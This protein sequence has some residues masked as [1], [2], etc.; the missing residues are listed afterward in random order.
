MSSEHKFKRKP[1]RPQSSLSFDENWNS[2][3]EIIKSAR[4]LF[5][6]DSYEN[7]SIRK[8]AE[9]SSVNPALIR[10]YFLN[11]EG[12]YCQVLSDIAED[13]QN[14][15]LNKECNKGE[16][17]PIELIIRSYIDF[18]EKQPEASN[19]FLK[20]ILLNEKESK[21]IDLVILPNKI[22][23]SKYLKL[24]ILGLNGFDEKVRLITDFVFNT[25]LQFILFEFI[26]DLCI[27]PFTSKSLDS[28]LNDNVKYI[29]SLFN[30]EVM[31]Y[32]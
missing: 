13:L 30:L 25:I 23:I 14:F 9:S 10:Y 3:Q 31:N 1:G 16:I 7:V 2:R 17:T 6:D 27:T 24:T 12:L 19:I 29:N 4:K 26:N 20:E 21:I 22:F 5:F 28:L 8:I 11:K 32:A 15:V 18:F